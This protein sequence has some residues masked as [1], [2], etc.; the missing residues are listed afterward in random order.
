MLIGLMVP[1]KAGPLV[2]LPPA[3]M[4]VSSNLYIWYDASDTAFV[5]MNA[6]N[7]VSKWID[8]SGNG[9]N[10]TQSVESA[11]PT[12]NKGATEDR[13][14]NFISFNNPSGATFN[15]KLLVGDGHLV[16]TSFTVFVVGK[17]RDNGPNYFIGGSV[18]AGA[19][20]N[21]GLGYYQDGS[22]ATG[23][24]IR[25]D[26]NEGG[27]IYT[28]IGSYLGASEPRRILYGYNVSGTDKLYMST[29]TSGVASFSQIDTATTGYLTDNDGMSIGYRKH[30]VTD[31]YLNGEINEIIMF[32]SGLTTTEMSNIETYLANKWLNDTDL[33]G[34]IE[35]YDEFPEDALMQDMPAYIDN[36][37]PAGP[38]PVTAGAVLWLDGMQPH[39]DNTNGVT[40]GSTIQTWVDFSPSRNHAGQ[41]TAGNRASYVTVN[42]N[43]GFRGM[44][45]GYNST[46]YFTFEDG[47]LLSSPQN[48]DAFI[49]FKEEPEWNAFNPI[50]GISRSFLKLGMSSSGQLVI[51]Q[52]GVTGYETQSGGSMDVSENILVEFRQ[53]TAGGYTQASIFKNGKLRKK[54]NKITSSLVGTSFPYTDRYLMREYGGN[55]FEGDLLEVILYNRALS[56]SERLQVTR[57]LAKKWSLY[58]ES[59][60]IHD[61]F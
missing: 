50:L 2:P 57:Y 31:R 56:E 4:A 54:F 23:E 10:A 44:R 53:E 40:V 6:S 36:L 16:N 17:R 14:Q 51:Y 55:Y 22:P 37:V 19:N 49:V 48:F 27:L 25:M 42:Q 41:I 33:D 18:Y 52:G 13:S 45:N 30:W 29:L 24:A 20:T 3:L 12:F 59:E 32:N 43:L 9:R 1:T 38:L 21:L 61:S 34:R 35:D 58:L 39:G 11:M 15:R 8:L 28:G 5:S 7:Q 46:R 26:Q 60:V 47:S